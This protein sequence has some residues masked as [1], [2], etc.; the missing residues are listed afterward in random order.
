MVFT[1]KRKEIKIL[2]LKNQYYRMISS[3]DNIFKVIVYIYKYKNLSNTIIT[4]HH[5][6]KHIFLKGLLEE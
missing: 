5:D 6:F 1:Q 2:L 3:E 4:T